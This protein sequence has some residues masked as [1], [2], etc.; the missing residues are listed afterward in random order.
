MGRRREKNEMK[1]EVEGERSP[2]PLVLHPPLD[3]A[4]L[5]IYICVLSK[6]T[7]YR[8]AIL[9]MLRTGGYRYR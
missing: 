4:Y 7:M 8:T 5:A 6:L 3:T 2:H 1:M 9:V